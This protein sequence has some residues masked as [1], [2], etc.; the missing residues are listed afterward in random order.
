MEK[1]IEKPIIENILVYK[2]QHEKYSL[3]YYPD[4]NTLDVEY[5]EYI[6]S[7]N[8]YD[9]MCITIYDINGWDL[10]QS[11]IKDQELLNKYLGIMTQYHIEKN[12]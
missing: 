6:E 1:D 12:I 9:D 2:I 4:S 8:D 3:L 5:E 11:P 10:L 7:E